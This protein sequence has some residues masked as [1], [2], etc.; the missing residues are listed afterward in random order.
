MKQPTP[1]YKVNDH[2]RFNGDL[3]LVRFVEFREHYW[4]Y[5]VGVLSGGPKNFS[6]IEWVKEDKLIKA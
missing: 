4:Y 3:A 6:F 2:V 1:K 5:Q